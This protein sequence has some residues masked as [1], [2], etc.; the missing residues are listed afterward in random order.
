MS[1]GLLK[2]HSV[3]FIILLVITGLYILFIWWHSTLT[4]DESTVESTNVLMFIINFLKSIGI[5]ADIT[6]YIIRKSAHFCEFALLGFLTLWTAYA[7]NK[8]VIKNLMSCGFICLSTAVV[9]E[10]VQIGSK[11]RSAEVG[12]VALDFSGAVA[13]TLF[14]ILILLLIKL[15]KKRG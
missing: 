12:D 4:A 5:K 15:F 3:L 9:D 8:A 7:K 14:F 6:D 11:G 1:R 13:G 10:L 2:K